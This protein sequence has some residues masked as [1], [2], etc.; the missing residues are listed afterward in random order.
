MTA[1]KDEPLRRD[2]GFLGSAFLS[3]NGVVGAGIFALAG[4]LVREVRRLQPLP[5]PACSACSSW[6]SRCP[7]PG[8]RPIIRVSGGPVVYA[9]AFGPA[10]VVPGRL[11][12]LC[13]PGDRAGREPDGARHLSR[14]ALAAARRT[15]CR[16]R[17]RDPRRGRR[18]SS[19]INVVG[20]K[21]AVRLLDAL[22]LL[23]AAPL[24]VVASG[25]PGRRGRLDRGA[26]RGTAALHRARGGGAAHP[27]C[28]RRLREQRRP[29]PAK[30]PT[31]SGPS[32]AP[33]SPRSSRPP[34][35]IS[36]SSSPTSR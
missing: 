34:L 21:R 16:P 23:K 24:L 27:L 9:A 1:A 31:R 2:I 14:Q 25:G 4:H 5:L 35:S 6:S 18:C 12:L 26:G 8:W 22:T 3:F 32:R 17:R 7:S 10:A 36:W 29:R 28:L 11:D 30:R 33:S 15:A 19:P 13:R 20:V